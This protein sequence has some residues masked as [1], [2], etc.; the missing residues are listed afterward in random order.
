MMSSIIIAWS[1]GLGQALVRSIPATNSTR[2]PMVWALRPTLPHRFTAQVLVWGMLLTFNRANIQCSV[3][4]KLD[5]AVI[6]MAHT[7]GAITNIALDKYYVN[8]IL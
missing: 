8:G 7:S 1:L 6:I 3:N 4:P 5:K 2:E